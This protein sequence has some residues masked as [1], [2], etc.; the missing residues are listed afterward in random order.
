M[1]VRNLVL[2]WWFVASSP[3]TQVNQLVHVHLES[4]RKKR[5]TRR[6][7]REKG[8]KKIDANDQTRTLVS[9]T[10]TGNDTP[11]DAYDGLVKCCRGGGAHIKD[12]LRQS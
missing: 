8:N 5:L 3:L 10:M 1:P 2:L 4:R 7:N 9:S 11:Q 12:S 6:V